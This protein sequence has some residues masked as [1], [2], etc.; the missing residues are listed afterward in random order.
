M[1]SSR[2]YNINYISSQTV[3]GGTVN[4]ALISCQTYH[5]PSTG[6]GL[7]NIV[8][9]TTPQLGGDLDSNSKAIYNATGLSGGAVSGGT[10]TAF[11]YYI[12]DKMYHIGD[13][14]TYIAF[15][16]N[17]INIYGNGI[18]TIASHGG[19]D[20][21]VTFGGKVSLGGYGLVNTEYVSSQIVSSSSYKGFI[22]KAGISLDGGGGVITS[23]T[24]GDSYIP[25]D[26]EIIDVTL[27]GRNSGSIYIDIWKDTLSNY[28]PTVADT[29]CGTKIASLSSNSSTG[30]YSSNTTLPSWT[31][32]ISDGDVLT[33]Y[34]S[35]CAHMEKCNLTLKLRRT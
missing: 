33:Y 2:F 12:A 27:M 7:S 10:I 35:S 9:D 11:D 1:G 32:S 14:D 25:Y 21:K 26:C 17:A 6:G 29:I 3:S 31:K 20:N 23:G 30:I 28:P 16:G 19:Q 18:T 5:G 13:V 4:T 15:G 34:V 8:E 22:E 24:K